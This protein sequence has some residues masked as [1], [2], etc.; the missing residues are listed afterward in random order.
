MHDIIQEV[1]MTMTV[2]DMKADAVDSNEVCEVITNEESVK[3][4]GI[5]KWMVEHCLKSFSIDQETVGPVSLSAQE[6]STFLGIHLLSRIGRVN[7]IICERER[8]ALLL[9]DVFIAGEIVTLNWAGFVFCFYRES[10][11]D[12]RSS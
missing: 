7:W 2:M 3:E 11:L 12:L 4:T 1:L 10:K 6:I 9:F 5:E 8:N